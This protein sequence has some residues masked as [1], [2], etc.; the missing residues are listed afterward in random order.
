[1]SSV[2]PQLLLIANP[3]PLAL[4]QVHGLSSIYFSRCFLTHACYL[5][6][7]WAWS[8]VH[9]SPSRFSWILDSDELS[10]KWAHLDW[11]LIFVWVG[12][13][14]KP[15][16]LFFQRLQVIFDVARLKLLAYFLRTEEGRSSQVWSTRNS[17]L[18][19]LRVPGPTCPSLSSLVHRAHTSSQ[20][21][22]VRSQSSTY[23]A[24]FQE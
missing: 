20:I 16:L 15:D 24:W 17:F 22:R 14:F 4:C 5:T 13:R 1:M 6:C 2:S 3:T 9:V 23:I 18:R 7:S 8:W 12:R 21:A 11:S 19:W 10:H